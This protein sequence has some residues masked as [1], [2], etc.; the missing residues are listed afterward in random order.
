M[1]LAGPSRPSVR[2]AKCSSASE[3]SISIDYPSK[4]IR[5]YCTVSASS[6]HTRISYAAH[7]QPAARLQHPCPELKCRAVKSA[8]FKCLTSAADV[9]VAIDRRASCHSPVC[10]P[11]SQ[12]RTVVVSRHLGA[13]PGPGL[14]SANIPSFS[15]SPSPRPSSRPSLKLQQSSNEALFLEPIATPNRCEQEAL[16]GPNCLFEDRGRFEVWVARDDVA[17]ISNPEV[18]SVKSHDAT[19]YTSLCARSAISRLLSYGAVEAE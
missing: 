17:V 9:G 15:P 5:G 2:N 10:S 19:P 1:P 4:R 11:A 14:V 12:A 16:A 13:S 18:P 7:L 6:S 3:V 8:S